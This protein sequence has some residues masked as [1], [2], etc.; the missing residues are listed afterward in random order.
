MVLTSKPVV[1]SRAPIRQ[2]SL[3]GT[4]HVDSWEAWICRFGKEVGARRVAQ[5]QL[6]LEVAPGQGHLSTNAGG[7][8]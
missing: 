1:F 3:Q 5:P 2:Y 7:R 8:E 4:E 6:V